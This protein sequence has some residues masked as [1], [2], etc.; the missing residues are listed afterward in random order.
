MAG[1]LR[2]ESGGSDSL[3]KRSWNKYIEK[4]KNKIKVGNFIRIEN[5]WSESQMYFHI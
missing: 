1:F 2:G 3:I 4:K 5:R